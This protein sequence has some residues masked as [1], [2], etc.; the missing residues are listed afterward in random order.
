[1]WAPLTTA[2]SV[3]RVAAA[4]VGLLAGGPH[5][6]PPHVCPT[7]RGAGHV[8]PHAPPPG[9]TL[10]APP[11]P[12]RGLPGRATPAVA[13]P[14]GGIVWTPAG[15]GPLAQRA[16]RS[17]TALLQRAS[18]ATALA[19][20]HDQQRAP[21]EHGEA[22]DGDDAR[23]VRD[24]A[25]ASVGTMPPGLVLRG[26]SHSGSSGPDE[27][28]ATACP[29]PPGSTASPFFEQSMSG[30]STPGA[31]ATTP[32]RRH[33]DSHGGYSAPSSGA[34]LGGGGGG[35]CGRTLSLH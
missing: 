20:A 31:H 22:C 24:A 26:H 19:A 23:C 12:G 1:V 8:H 14:H 18:L 29:P 6:F 27:A 33:G 10:L 30:W 32:M 13:A 21:G 9:A 4:R 2:T 15:T 35:D 3:P 7:P 34:S 25:R 17:L 16:A 28:E 5:H 11:P